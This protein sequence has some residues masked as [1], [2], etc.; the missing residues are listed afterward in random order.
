[1]GFRDGF[2]TILRPITAVKERASEFIETLEDQADHWRDEATREHDLRVEG[3]VDAKV[4]TARAKYWIAVIKANGRVAVAKAEATGI[5]RGIAIGH[6]RALDETDVF[7]AGFEG[8]RRRRN[9]MPNGKQSSDVS[10]NQ[11]GIMGPPSSPRG[12]QFMSECS[13]RSKNPL[14]ASRKSDHRSTRTF[15][16]T[17]PEIKKV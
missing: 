10:G 5:A 1:M 2:R 12:K 3:L 16:L 4:A 13:G 15:A 14:Q 11:A 9:S 8:G 7:D 6:Q 17:A